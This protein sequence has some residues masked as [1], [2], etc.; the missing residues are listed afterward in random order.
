MRMFCVRR[1]RWK[2]YIVSPA[3]VRLRQ[4]PTSNLTLQHRQLVA[5]SR[6]SISFSR[7]ERKRST[8]TSS[9]RRSDQYRNDKMI[10]CERLATGS[11]P[12]VQR[13]TGVLGTHRV[14]RVGS[15]S[16]EA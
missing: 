11:D 14:D 12:T 4:L 2:S 10:P 9:S 6:I 15:R 8:A 13:R 7:S 1:S 5:E 16:R 3:K